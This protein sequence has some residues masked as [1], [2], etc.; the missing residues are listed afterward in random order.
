[1]TLDVGQQQTI[2]LRL[3]G[4]TGYEWVLTTQG[5]GGEVEIVDKE[6][7]PED[8]AFGARLVTRFLIRGVR[9]GRLKLCAVLKRP[10]EE[11]GAEAREYSVVVHD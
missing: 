2:D 10:W 5:D 8:Q 4:G 3:P 9:P 11:E 1:M 7:I 6:L